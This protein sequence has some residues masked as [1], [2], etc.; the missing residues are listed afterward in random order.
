HTVVPDRTAKTLRRG[1]NV[2]RTGVND[3]DMRVVAG[4]VDVEYGDLRVQCG[5]LADTVGRQRGQTGTGDGTGSEYSTVRS[6]QGYPARAAVDRGIDP[7]IAVGAQGQAVTV[8]PCH[9][10]DNPDRAGPE[11]RRIC[12]RYDHR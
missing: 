8:A 12:G 1:Q 11:P 4:V 9:C 7:D 5:A 10:V 2:E 6:I 3:V